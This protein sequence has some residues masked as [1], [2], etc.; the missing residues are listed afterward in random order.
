MSDWASRH[1]E[2]RDHRPWCRLVDRRG[3]GRVVD[4]LLGS[5]ANIV[6]GMAP[7]SQSTLRRR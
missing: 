5:A 6:D 7:C 2:I 1:I 3:G 4:A